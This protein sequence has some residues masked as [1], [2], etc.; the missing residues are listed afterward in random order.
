MLKLIFI[1]NDEKLAKSA[2]NAGVDRI[3][4]DL[5]ILGKE[6]R[7]IG[8]N[9][10]ISRHTIEDVYKIRETIKKADLLVRVNPIHE[11]S[12][13]EINEVIN[14]GA[15]MIMLPMFRTR[16]D[17]STFLKIVDG[18]AR[19]MP[20][21]EH[22]EAVNN[23][24]E[25]ISLSG[26]DELHIGLNDLH[27]SM[28]KKF[29]FELLTDS[30]VDNIIKKVSE[31]NIPT[32]IGGMSRLGTGRLPADLILDEQYRLHSNGVILSRGFIEDIKPEEEKDISSFFCKH[33]K[34]IRD[35]EKRL[36]GESEKYFAE[37][38]T[39]L[40]KVIKDIVGE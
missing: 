6:T 39:Q 40:E 13:E 10:R 8:R 32:G 16:E 24:D 28:K 4:V 9:T 17:V 31:K 15:D 14:A 12:R 35:T 11:G 33:I 19:V 34:K 25:I 2:E 37:R 1:T 18:R 7:Q 22:I 27:I 20:L 5:E 29:M 3:L 26:I 30:T 23:L 36:Q 38:H 21:L